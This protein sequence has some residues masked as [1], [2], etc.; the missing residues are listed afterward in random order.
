[1]PKVN[2]FGVV[3]FI[4]SFLFWWCSFLFLFIYVLAVVVTLAF[5]F[6]TNLKHDKGIKP[7]CMLELKDNPTNVGRIMV[8]N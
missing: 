7:I 5:S 4:F 1:M 2:H 8:M 3:H 6:A